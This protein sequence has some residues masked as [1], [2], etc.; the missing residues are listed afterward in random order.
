MGGTTSDAVGRSGIYSCRVQHRQESS[1]EIRLHCS[2]HWDILGGTVTVVLHQV[3]PNVRTTT[4]KPW[5]GRYG[6]EILSLLKSGSHTCY[7]PAL[8]SD[9]HSRLLQ[10][11]K[12]SS[13]RRL[14]RWLGQQKTY[15]GVF[16][17]GCIVTALAYI[18]DPFLPFNGVIKLG[19]NDST[20]RRNVGIFKKKIQFKQ[21]L[22]RSN[23]LHTTLEYT[24]YK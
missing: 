22:C 6:R 1:T 21:H 17:Y 19:E 16:I 18:N 15:R 20:C 24:E 10:G 3:G 9:S 8:R 5:G 13:G 12:E 2:S 11:M 23:W 4:V 7:R 14:K